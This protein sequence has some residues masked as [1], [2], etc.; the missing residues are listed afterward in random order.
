MKTQNKTA[1]RTAT[2]SAKT[3]SKGGKASK[4]ATVAQVTP[5]AAPAPVAQAPAAPVVNA[6]AAPVVRKPSKI[7]MLCDL[8]DAAK[9]LA[10]LTMAEIIGKLGE[11]KA[12]GII[13]AP[14]NDCGPNGF[15]NPQ[16]ISSINAMA[17]P[18]WSRHQGRLFRFALTTQQGEVILNTSGVEIHGIAPG[19]RMTNTSLLHAFGASAKAPAVISADAWNAM[20]ASEKP[21]SPRVLLTQLLDAQA[22][23]RK[24]LLKQE[25]AAASV[26]APAAPVTAPAPVGAPAATAPSGKAS[27]AGAGKGGASEIAVAAVKASTP[28]RKRAAAAPAGKK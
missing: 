3:T 13:S 17:V 27:K 24:A 12:A 19:A 15:K 11:A 7:G 10:P 8:L 2:A 23:A 26:A 28:A 6:P 4:P 25:K 14:A 21:A 16:T 1:A 9:T 5:P 22:A 18:S 20:P